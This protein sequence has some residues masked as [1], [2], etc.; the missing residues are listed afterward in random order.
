MA[1]LLADF[2]RVAHFLFVLFVVGGLALTWIGAIADWRWVRN[3]WFRVAHLIAIC[4]V[5]TLAL[6]R[7][8]CPL[9]VWE[10]ALRG[11]RADD[12]FV[13]RWTH[14]VLFYSFPEWA[15]TSAYVLF[16]LLVAATW[17]RVR[18]QGSQS[19]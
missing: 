14:R 16:A 13:A 12:S 10:A 8:A 19:R 15:F 6:L 11:T 4:I 9:T 18:P 1:P 17:W 5:A 7:I 2:V 3:W